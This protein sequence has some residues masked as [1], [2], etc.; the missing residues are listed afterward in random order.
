MTRCESAHERAGSD[1]VLAAHDLHKHFGG[2]VVLDC[3][4]L[5]LHRGEV[6]LLRG[7]NGSGKTTLLNI[8]TGNLE[9]DAGTIHLYANDQAE[10]FHFPR[11]WWQEL[12]PFDHFTPE[13]V[14]WEGVGRTWQEIRL[15]PT[16]SLL[17]NICVASPNQ[18]GE[19]PFSALC[20]RG[21]VRHQETDIRSR[22]AAILGKV[23]MKGRE[24]SSA[25]M[26]SLGQS[27][28]IAIARAVEAGASI[29]FLDE[30]LAG[31]DAAGI[32][33]VMGLLKQLATDHKVTLVIIEHV[34]NIPRVLDL[35]TTVWTLQNKKLTVHKPST[36]RAEV[37]ISVG[38]GFCDLIRII[39]GD[40]KH[41]INQQLPGG[42]LLTT[43]SRNKKDSLATKNTKEL[44][45]EFPLPLRERQDEGFSE[46]DTPVLEV[47]DLIV[48]RGR[49]LVIGERGQ[50]GSV[51]GLSFT[52]DKSEIAFLQAPNGWG[53]TTLLLAIAGIL[54]VTSGEI[55]LDGK[56]IHKLPPWERAKCGLSLLQSRDHVFINLTVRESLQLCG[57]GKA[58]ANLD[59]LLDR[60]VSVLSGGERQRLAIVCS[61][62]RNQTLHLQDEPFSALDVSAL[63]A[64][65][66]SLRPHP[67]KAFLVAVPTSHGK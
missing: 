37:R 34:F 22:A 29:L 14:A 23:G 15:F 16:H 24:S 32:N 53:K 28:R 54:P 20:R 18:K 27:K 41:I 26:V 45:K 21:T 59:S 10:H 57:V 48:H 17:D 11:H 58:S 38:D 49:R 1:V 33:E 42:A 52:L 60:R 12:N 61:Q 36:V 66:A 63:R 55:R 6:V 2:Q 7:H 31:L 62:S 64:F 44:E 46:A 9:P 47:K 65:E 13:R 43:I 5:E 30:P 3:V 19:N 4:S 50:D 67:S 25:D 8:L 56:P 39:A 35:A 40:N 51:Q